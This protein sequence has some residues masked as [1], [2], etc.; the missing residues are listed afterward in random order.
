MDPSSVSPQLATVVVVVGLNAILGL[1]GAA[2]S[3]VQ[4]FRRQPPIDQTLANYARIGDVN[5]IEERNNRTHAEIFAIMRTQQ[6]SNEKTFAD[7]ERV[8]GRIEGKLD[9]CPTVCGGE[10]NGRPSPR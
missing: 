1:V 3:I 7:I 8:L 9:R 5:G 4:T 10:S 6:A 2:C